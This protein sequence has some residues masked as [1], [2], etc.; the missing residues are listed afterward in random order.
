MYL[1]PGPNGRVNDLLGRLVDQPM[2]ICFEFDPYFLHVPLTASLIF[3]LFNDLADH[4]RADSLAAF[5]DSKTQFF[6]HRDRN[7]QLDRQ[8]HVIAGHAHFNARRKFGRAGDIRRTEIELGTIP[9]KERRYD[10]R[11]LP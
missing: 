8:L 2:I 9:L 4:A 1:G 10:D 6:F 7:D 5:T 3:R 11:L